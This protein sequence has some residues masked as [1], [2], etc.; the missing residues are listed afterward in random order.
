MLKAILIFVLLGSTAMA[1]LTGKTQG[2][3]PS[4]LK[5]LKRALKLAGVDKNVQVL[6]GRRS[7]A[8]VKRIYQNELKRKRGIDPRTGK[9]EKGYYSQLVT[10][11]YRPSS[12]TPGHRL[13]GGLDIAAGILGPHQEDFVDFMLKEGF[14]VIDERK[15]LEEVFVI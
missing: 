9:K 4:R 8:S 12:V 10:S 7:M 15:A 11:D 2:L 6:S 1:K 3:S 13:Y 14:R 5:K